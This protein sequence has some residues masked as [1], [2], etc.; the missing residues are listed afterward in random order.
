MA[1]RV[2]DAD[3]DLGFFKK[4]YGWQEDAVSQMLAG[5][6]DFYNER[7]GQFQ[8]AFVVEVS[9]SGGKSVYSLKAARSTIE[10]DMIDMAVVVVPR[11]T[12]KDGFR[13]DA[14]YVKM[15]P[16]YQRLGCETIRVDT[17]LKASSGATMM[18]N[19]HVAV[20]MYQS[21]SNLLGLFEMWS[22]M[23]KRLLFIFDEVHHGKV[24]DD[25]DEGDESDDDCAKEWG[26]AMEAVRPFAHSIICMTGTPVRTDGSRVPYL[27]YKNGEYIDPKNGVIRKAVFV[28]ADY[29][30]TYKD[31]IDR[32]L[33][34]KLIFQVQDPTVS[35][36]YQEN[37]EGREYERKLSGVPKNHV[38]YAKQSLFDVKNGLVDGVLRL[39]HADNSVDRKNGDDDAAILVVTGPTKGDA[40]PLKLVA[41]RIRGLF[42]EDAVTVESK[43]GDQAHEE[44]RIFKKGAARWIISK[45]MINEG[46]SIPRIRQIVILRDIKSQVRFDQ[47]VHRATRN[48]SDTK[49]QDAK[50]FLFR[51]PI[52][53]TYVGLIEDAMRA[54]IE[55]PKVLCPGCRHEL[56]F[57]PREDKPCPYCGYE[58]PITCYPPDGQRDKRF[59]WLFG[60][61]DD[62]TV[63]QGGEDFT[64][65]DYMSRAILIKLGPNPVYGGR[66]PINEILITGIRDG[67]FEA[68]GG[69]PK[70]PFSAEEEMNKHWGRGMQNCESAAG[71]IASRQGIPYQEAISSVIG[72]CKRMAG[73]PRGK[74]AKQRVMRD[75]PDA[76]AKFKKFFDGSVD[77]VKR[78]SKRFGG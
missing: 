75:D 18:T 70:S 5:V 19:I 56:E 55:R 69:K 45:D 44:V 20:V 15:A 13:D 22:K 73:F 68:T 14:K 59:T 4:D 36:I 38:E 61:L 31:A 74:D 64:S 54:I 29:T 30:L 17:S 53:M 9:P 24:S 26:P 49:H 3:Q 23:G 63:V 76:P 67:L 57:R 8:H 35:Y 46:T 52:M 10:A 78:T 27:R 77:V 48:R 39:A 12:I 16:A 62:E 65:V 58:P 60:E 47:T 50:V 25:S 40:N 32:G 41:D 34:R 7:T 11:E 37:G 2:D 51:L 66:H 33:A 71:V 21:L 43:D 72:E 28:E 42:N 1:A 6:S